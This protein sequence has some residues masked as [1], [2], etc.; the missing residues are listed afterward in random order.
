MGRLLT[1]FCSI[2]GFRIFHLNL[3]QRRKAKHKVLENGV[4]H[5][6]RYRLFKF[7]IFFFQMDII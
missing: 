1:M 3:A 5:H 6:L 2:N 4:L 7:P